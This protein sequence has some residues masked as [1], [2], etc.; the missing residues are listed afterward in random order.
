MN[1]I[2][3]EALKE[4]MMNNPFMVEY[5]LHPQY[6][7]IETYPTGQERRRARREQKRKNKKK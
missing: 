7:P 5:S 2:E 6:A 1:P 4:K 3:K